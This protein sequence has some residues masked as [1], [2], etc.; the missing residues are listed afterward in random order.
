MEYIIEIL[1]VYLFDW[2]G[3]FNYGLT[4]DNIDLFDRW[5]FYLWGSECT[6]DLDLVHQGRY[7]VAT[8]LNVIWHL[9]TG[10]PSLFNACNI[11]GI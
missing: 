2:A 8:L 4:V 10:E 1:L 9:L 11:E 7:V 6:T 5:Y 3:T